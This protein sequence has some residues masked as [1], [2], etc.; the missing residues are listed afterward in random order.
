MVAGDLADLLAQ[1]RR[2][3]QQRALER[4]EALCGQIL[5]RE[6]GHAATL[7]MLGLIHQAAHRHQLAIDNYARAIAGD[8]LNAAYRYNIAYS[9][10]TLHRPAAAAAHFKTALALS[11]DDVAVESFLMQ[12]P[13]VVEC[14][15]RAM[16]QSSLP[17]SANLFGPREISALAND[18]LLRCAMQSIL[19]RGI[20]LEFLLTHLRLALL[21]LALGAGSE[22]IAED[23]ASLFCALGE[24]CFINE[25]V[26]AQG[27]VEAT[28][29]DL[30]RDR[31]LASLSTGA[32]TSPT[33]LAA[34]A[35]Y[36]PLH[37]LAN[38]GSLLETD[39]PQHVTD[40][41]TRQVRQPMEDAH[42]RRSIPTLTA[43]DD[44]TS[45]QVMNQYEEN[46]Y[47]CWTLQPRASRG[48]ATVRPA[49]TADPGHRHS[50]Q[51]IL[52]A[53][54][55]TG[56][57]AIEIAQQS[58]EARVLA[59]DISRSSLAYARRKTREAGL[60]NIEYAQA[61][62]LKS[63]AIGRRFDRIEA[64]GVL[65][66]LA[67]PA[68]GLRALLTLLKPDGILRLGLYSEA[69]RRAWSIV[70]ARDLIAQGGYRPTPEGI[71]ALRQAIIGRRHEPRWRTLLAMSADFYSMSGCR[72]LLFNIVE[73]RFTISQ[74]E[75]LL[76]QHNLSFIGFQVDHDTA[77]QFRRRHP[78]GGADN[79]LACWN[80]FEEANPHTFH[81]MY[82]FAVR[83]DGHPPH[84]ADRVE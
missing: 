20:E 40:L 36:F 38:A 22:K 10:Q 8:E 31:L 4:A 6:P 16:A 59:I 79:N 82:M 48:G 74:I 80:A 15:K 30:A 14:V 37:R 68:A 55:G 39:H 77:E 44:A 84:G 13:D 57:H 32:A 72:D 66:H 24:Q 43:I 51:E 64:I 1:A 53:G 62:I 11:A 49:E 23:V 3:Y 47:P 71:R 7:N 12:N 75:L 33:L 46:P 78:V 42:D 65:H 29:A 18:I 73:H 25:Y 60:R 50:S 41:L 45:I 5:A 52:V 21:R 27:D 70:D 26:L 63:A 83:K 9:Y 17:A 19:L 35:A 54:C 67:D 34:V 56:R 61:D 28:E 76:K 2:A 81:R 58:P 69:A